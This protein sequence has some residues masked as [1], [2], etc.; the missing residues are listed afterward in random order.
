MF[1]SWPFFP[2]FFHRKWFEAADPRVLEDDATY[3]A[4]PVVPD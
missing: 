3:R 2:Q 4:T 1:A